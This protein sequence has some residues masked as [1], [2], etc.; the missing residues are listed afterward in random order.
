MAL[1]R[2]SQLS[3]TLGWAAAMDVLLALSGNLCDA[4]LAAVAGLLL[5]ARDWG[6]FP[7]AT[8]L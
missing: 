5:L 6:L 1:Q 8:T 2:A 4:E 7:P 3:S